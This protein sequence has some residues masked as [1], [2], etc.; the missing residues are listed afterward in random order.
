MK[1][2][3]PAVR[4]HRARPAEFLYRPLG[5]AAQSG[6]ADARARPICHRRRAAAHGAC[7]LRALAARPCPHQKHRD[8][9]SEE[10]ARRRRGR[11]RRRACQGDHA[12]GRRAHASQGHQIGA[13]ARH[14]RRARLLAGRGGVRR[15][16]AHAR[17]EAEDA[18]ALVGVD[19]EIA[20]RRHRSGNGAR[21]QNAGHPSRAWRQSHLRA[22]AQCRRAGQGFCRGRR[23][24]RDDIYVRPPYR[25]HQRAARHRRRLESGRSSA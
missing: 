2:S 3:R 8:G 7:R 17:A 25:R 18:C 6:A 24:G 15:R 4:P 14:R 11:H 5:A 16:R 21:R 20:A 9:G 12:L 1:I 22:R 19:Y 13:A 10:S 23:R